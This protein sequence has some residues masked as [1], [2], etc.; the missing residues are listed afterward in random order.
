MRATSGWSSGSSTASGFVRQTH[1]VDVF[2]MAR[3]TYHGYRVEHEPETGRAGQSAVHWLNVY[4]GTSPTPM[5][6]V[7]MEVNWSYPLRLGAPGHPMDAQWELARDLGIRW[8]HGLIDLGRFEPGRTYEEERSEQWEAEFGDADLDDEVLRREVLVAL[9]R[10]NRAE[11]GSGEIF[12]L[13]VD[14]VADVLGTS[15]T[16]V[17]GIVS[18]LLMEGLAEP[19]APTFGRGASDGSCRI[20]GAGLQALRETSVEQTASIVYVDEIDSFSKVRRVPAASVRGL[21]SRGLLSLPEDE[22]KQK[23]CE[24]V[25]ENFEHKDWGG[26]RSDVFTTQI[27]H[28]G[29][30]RAAAW[31]LKGPSAGPVMYPSSLG[32]RA[33]QD[34]RLFTEPA[35]L[36]LVQSNG[37]IDSAVIHR[38]RLLA[39]ER[40]RR[41]EA[42]FLC[43]IDGTDT[44]RL[45]RAYWFL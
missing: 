41:G 11:Q 31:L 2:G 27:M 40:A 4:E 34:L 14:G 15:G 1:G 25:G 19:A 13:D 6:R 22:V 20:T 18:E 8:V 21:L 29:K 39:D 38:L 33:D 28:A 26:E 24:I 17:R 16:R 42:T 36:F 3:E 5:F 7:R 23:L 43:F 9:K 45:L 10:M 30:R 37:R 12:D 44:A 35:E 32:K